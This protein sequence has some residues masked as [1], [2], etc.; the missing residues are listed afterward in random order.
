MKRREF[1]KSLAAATAISASPLSL[2][3]NA[4]AATR[5]A[6]AGGGATQVFNYANF[7]GNLNDLYLANASVL[8][9]ALQL[10]NSG[11]GHH[12]AQ[13]WYRTQQPPGSFTTTFSFQFQGITGV[14][15]GVQS[16]FT[17][18]IQ[19]QA[20]SPPSQPGYTGYG[21][22]GDA[23][24]CGYGCAQLS[25]DQY[26]PQDSLGIKFDAGSIGQTYPNNGLPSSTGMYLNAGTTCYPGK[27]LAQI[28][29]VDLNPFGLNF[30]NQ[31][32]CTATIVYDGSFLTMVISDTSTNAQ[33]R[34]VWPLNLPATT[35]ANGNWVGF[36][37]GTAR[38]GYFLI[39]NWTYWSG[40]NTRLT[41][42][43]FSVASGQ[44]A[45]AQ[46]VAIN[47]P[48][49][50]ICYYTINGLPPTSSS[51]QYTGPIT[52]SANAFVQ[53]VAIQSGYTDSY[54]GTASYQIGNYNVINYPSGFDSG[55]LILCGYAYLSGSTVRVSDNTQSTGSAVWY[56]GPVA[57][58]SFATSF[59]VNYGSQGQGMAFVLQNTPPAFTGL[60]GVQITG[61][62]GQISFNA[63]KIKVGDYVTISGTNSGSG[64]IGGY[65]NQAIYSIGATNGSTTATLTTA[66]GWDSSS[67]PGSLI[68]GKAVSTT[69][70]TPAGL[71]F[72]LNAASFTGGPTVVGGSNNA[73]GY[74][75]MDAVNGPPWGAAPGI[76]SSVAV[77]INQQSFTGVSGGNNDPANGVGLYTNGAAPY[78]SQIATGLN[79]QTGSWNVTLSYD[80]TTLTFTMQAAGGGTKF[81]HSWA[82]NIPSIVGAN[83]AYAGFT[84]GT[85]GAASVT[86][87]Q[88][89]TYTA[90]SVQTSN[91]VPAA[92]TN[93]QVK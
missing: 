92:P 15:G 16:G 23:N 66:V 70:G 91:P 38:Q 81:T 31:N 74:G 29:Y 85:Y 42:P 73:I 50:S 58:N 2:I 25:F 36:S 54:I 3:R 30:Y 61:S 33:A 32:V 13:A 69:A 62:G 20:F 21:A 86:A 1:N 53:A 59:T 75:G 27:G 56:P 45:G 35:N 55:S 4:L 57:V 78:G 60:T 19:N 46:S 52:I 12:G 87:I 83:T 67:S 40:Y 71:T 11:N 80:G 47:A 90:S 88:S 44:Y 41:T 89:W 18:Y 28:P 8:G 14:A 37:A 64:S 26:P 76:L 93:L 68:A 63:T 84:G 7:T 6:T 5:A 48:S 34:F 65:S 49:G 24:M 22:G 39:N 9:S 82:V 17:F 51:T 77:V 43:T 79:F 10:I 72:S